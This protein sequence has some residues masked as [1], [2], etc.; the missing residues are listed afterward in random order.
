M[1]MYWRGQ[2]P[3][4]A[5]IFGADKRIRQMEILTIDLG[6]LASVLL[7]AIAAG[8]AGRLIGK[9]LLR[10]GQKLAARTKETSDDYLVL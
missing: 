8:V 10:Y 2:R 5:A 7:I 4:R 9:V 1:K 3:A 6:K